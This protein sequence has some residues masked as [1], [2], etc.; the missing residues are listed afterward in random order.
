[1]VL[2]EDEAGRRPWGETR[3]R[4]KA[5][6][7]FFPARTIVNKG[8]PGMF[9]TLLAGVGLGLALCKLLNQQS[10]KGIAPLPVPVEP[11][12][13]CNPLAVNRLRGYLDVE[14]N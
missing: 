9:V 3:G 10:V 13:R 7:G 11:I 6:L 12:Q 2:G 14:R 4:T 8:V 5:V 1:M